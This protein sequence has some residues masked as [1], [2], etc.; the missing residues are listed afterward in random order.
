M[1]GHRPARAATCRV[2][3]AATWHLALAATRTALAALCVLALVAACSATGS[4]SGSGSAQD[5]ATT[6][7]MSIGAQ[8]AEASLAPVGPTLGGQ[9]AG[10]LLVWLASKPEQPQR[11]DAMFDAYLV[12]PDG[13]PID[14]ATV[15]FDTDMTNMSHGKYLVPTE[16]TGN[17]HYV[18][19][20]HF[21]MPGPWRVI[22]LVER[23]GNETVKLRFEFDVGAQLGV[24]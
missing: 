9:R 4:G 11:G 20:V 3:R 18:G 6:G 24:Q 5:T 17:G 22:A 8:D 23:P 1:V 14:N 2:A 13:Q 10:N 12:Q 19:Q 16:A 21:S 7:S 15:T